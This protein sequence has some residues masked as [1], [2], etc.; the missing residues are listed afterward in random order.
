MKSRKDNINKLKELCE[1]LSDRDSQLKINAST[2]WMILEK[3][4]SVRVSLSDLKPICEDTK[5]ALNSSLTTLT[6]IE[7]LVSNRGCKKV[8][9]HD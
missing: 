3:V 4:E 5:G 7:D 9:E 8:V 2:L 6:E 1:E